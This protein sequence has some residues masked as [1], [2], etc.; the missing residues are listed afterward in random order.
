MKSILLFVCL[1]C[2][3]YSFGQQKL[4]SMVSHHYQPDS[5]LF[6]K[7]SVSFIYYAWQGSIEHLKPS[8]ELGEHSLSWEFPNIEI[9]C[10]EEERYNFNPFNLVNFKEKVSYNGLVIESNDQSYRVLN[11]YDAND[12]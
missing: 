3:S 5:S 2:F 7:D 10:D 8:F 11:F 9:P 6:H 12:N 1:F 4:L